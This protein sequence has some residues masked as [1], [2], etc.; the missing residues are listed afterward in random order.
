MKQ[1]TVLITGCGGMLGQDVYKS[2]N[3]NY[4]KVVASDIDL[5]E[6]WLEY[7]DVRNAT[8]CRLWVE[9]LRPD[10]IVNLAAH[11]DLEYCEE[12]KKDAW[13]TNALG[14]EN[15][16]T[17]A[18][19]YGALY[20]YISTAGVFDGKQESYVDDDLAVPINEY[21]RSKYHGEVFIQKH[22]TEYF[23]FR[24]GWMM[25]GEDKDKKFV[26]KILDQ[27][28]AGKTELFVVNDKLGTPTYTGDFAKGIIKVIESNKYGLYNQVCSGS[29]SRYDVAIKMIEYLGLTGKIKVTKVNSDHFK[30]EYFAPRPYSEILINQKLNDLGINFMRDWDVCL[31]EYCELLKVQ[32]D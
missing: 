11:T 19:E 12:N 28:L 17:L 24:A 6:P 10:I 31:K 29:G 5:N 4:E 2:F 8:E 7:L 9:S 21:S 13:N 1:E 18:K 16:A 3:E 15:L 30:E 32:L 23:I 22:N 26:K 27:L 14:A 25:G 20:I